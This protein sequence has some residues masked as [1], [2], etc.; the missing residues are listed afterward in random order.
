MREAGNRVRI[1]AQLVEAVTGNHIW[2]ECYDREL[3]DI[4]AVQDEVTGTIVS[5]LARHIEKVGRQRVIGKSTEDLAAYDC[6]LLG[7]RC[8]DQHSMDG[9]LRA[10]QMF[11]RAID[12]EP[13]SARAHTGLARTYLNEIWTAWEVPE[14]AA[15]P[16]IVL[17]KKAV[18]LDEL[19]GR[20]RVYVANAYILTKSN[21]E[22]AEQ[23]DKTVAT[24]L[25][26]AGVREYA[27][28]KLGQTEHSLPS[29]LRAMV[30]VFAA[31]RVLPKFLGAAYCGLYHATKTG[32]MERFYGEVSPIEFEWYLRTERGRARPTSR[33][34]RRPARRH[35]PRGRSPA[36][37]NAGRRAAG[38][39]ADRREGRRAATSRGNA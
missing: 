26:T 3:E 24:V 15:K 12:L 8:L 2:A 38:P 7:D 9:I 23:P 29:H 13:G 20:A 18:A 25:S 36:R 34:S 39:L 1:T 10:R 31:A 17:A 21:Y 30:D 19:D 14:A 5:T 32:K 11:Q 16:A 27:P 35:R 22:L 28:G 4:F 6:L 37:R 33:A